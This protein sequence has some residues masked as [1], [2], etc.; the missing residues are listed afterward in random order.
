M[1]TTNLKLNTAK[2]MDGLAHFVVKH[3]E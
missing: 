1:G 3:S 2:K